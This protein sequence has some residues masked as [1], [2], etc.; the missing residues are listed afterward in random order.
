MML[1]FIERWR[2]MK[3][4]IYKKVEY[5]LYNYKD[6]DKKIEEIRENTIDS[7]SISTHSHLIGKNSLEDQAI[8]LAENKKVYELKKAKVIVAHF[9]KVFKERNS[10][11][12]EFIKMKYFEKAS[13]IKIDKGT[14]NMS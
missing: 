3:E 14:E 9:L 4:N 12:Y 6:I 5:H 8:K 13:P 7:V 1:F 11:R 10:K 2:I